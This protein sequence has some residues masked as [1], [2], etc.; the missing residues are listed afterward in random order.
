MIE[1]II[2][3][4]LAFYTISK[5]YRKLSLISVSYSLDY[6]LYIP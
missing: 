1:Y 4:K 5:I 6:C 3:Q 2:I